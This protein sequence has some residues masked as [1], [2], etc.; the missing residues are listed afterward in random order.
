MMVTPALQEMNIAPMNRYGSER[1]SYAQEY[2]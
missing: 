2:Q 1:P